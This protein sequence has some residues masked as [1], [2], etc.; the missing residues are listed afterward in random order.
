MA[1][2]PLS[3]RPTNEELVVLDEHNVRWSEFCRG[4]INRLKEGKQLSRNDLFDKIVLRTILIM[5]GCLIVC[6]TPLLND[7]I[8]IMFEYMV[9]ITMVFI[10]TISMIFLWRD[11][12]SRKRVS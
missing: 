9:G 2:N 12:Y 11:N 4:N 1:E 8:L 10:G 5:L 6:F 3:F 7:I